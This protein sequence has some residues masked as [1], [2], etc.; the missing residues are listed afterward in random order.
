MYTIEFPNCTVTVDKHTELIE[1]AN[2]DYVY[3]LN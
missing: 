2:A 3:I 1:T